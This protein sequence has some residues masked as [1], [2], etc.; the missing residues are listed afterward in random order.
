MESSAFL[1]NSCQLSAFSV[2]LI[3]IF[4]WLVC[5]PAW[6]GGEWIRP[7]RADDPLIWVVRMVGF[8]GI[9]SKGGMSGPRGLI[10]I[11]VP[12]AQL[13]NFAAIE[14]VIVGYGTR[15]SRMSFSELDMSQLDPGQRGNASGFLPTRLAGNCGRLPRLP[16]VVEILAASH[17]NVPPLETLSV[18]LEVNAFQYTKA[19]VYVVATM[20]SD[21]PNEIRFAVFHY[22]DSPPIEELTTT[23]TMGNYE[24]LHHPGSRDRVVDSRD[25]TGE[26]KEFRDLDNFPLVEMLRTP[27]GDADVFCTANEASAPGP[28]GA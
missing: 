2:Q 26:V 11:G 6:A 25:T 20:V 18:R 22:P 9:A 14:P 10:R 24:R 13:V 4:V 7:T 15:F 5:V 23:A 3:A 12:P 8:F 21:Q 27:E 28:R 16:S 1:R 19:H 17:Q